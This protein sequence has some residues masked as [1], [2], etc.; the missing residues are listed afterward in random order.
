MKD[1]RPNIIVILSDDWGYGDL[2]CYG[3]KTICTPNID[4][5]ASEGSRYE[6]FYVTS[7]VCSPSR[8]SFITGHYPARWGIEGHLARFDENEERNIPN[9]LDPSAPSL[10]KILNENGYRTAHYGKWHLG[11][12]GGLHGHPDAPTVKSYGY[13]DTRTWNG[14]GPTWI[15]KDQWPHTQYNDDD[16]IWAANSSELAVDATLD[17]IEAGGDEPFFINLWIKDPHTPLHPTEE[18][19]E[20]FKDLPEPQQTYYSVLHNADHQLGRLF[21]AVG[22]REDSD[23][24]IIIFTSDNGPE[25]IREDLGT[26]GSTGGLKG[27]KRSLYDGGTRVPFIVKWPSSTPKG[28]VNDTLMSSVDLFPT[29]LKLSGAKIPH[30]YIPDGVNVLKQLKGEVLTRSHPMMWQWPFPDPT[31]DLNWP[32]L[33]IRN[34]DFCLIMNPDL[35]RVELYRS[36][37]DFSQ[38]KE[39]SSEYPKEV[40]LLKEWALNW[41]SI[42]PR[43]S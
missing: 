29:L 5:L 26:F 18:Q 39:C 12:G 43:N 31:D 11:G 7:P 28:V 23:N 17:F 38:E 42:N 14:N 10:P 1:K 41:S 36:E 4:K 16:Q 22:E 8:C 21:D 34:Q 37:G 19:R 9:W 25:M 33:A 3:N 24:T 6:N 30:G 27:R 40:E 13:D 15:G 20:P 2:G 32:S 35:D